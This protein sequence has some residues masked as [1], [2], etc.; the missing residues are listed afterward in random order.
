LAEDTQP[1]RCGGKDF[2]TPDIKKEIQIALLASRA[3]DFLWT[4]SDKRERS[5]GTGKEDE[6]G[7]RTLFKKKGKKTCRIAVLKLP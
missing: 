7:K 3:N 5:I 4:K 1:P 2:T 6:K